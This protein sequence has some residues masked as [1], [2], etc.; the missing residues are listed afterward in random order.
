[1]MRKLTR[2]FSLPVIAASV[3]ILIALGAIS[4]PAQMRGAGQ[5]IAQPSAPQSLLSPGGGEAGHRSIPPLVRPAPGF[6]PQQAESTLFLSPVLY[7]VAAAGSLIVADVNGDGKPDIVAAGCTDAF[8]CDWSGVVSVLLGNGD[9]TFQQP[10]TFSTGQLVGA[11]AMAD[12]NHDGKLDLVLTNGYQENGYAWGNTVSV[13]LGN[14]DGTFQPPI[15]YS[16]VGQTAYSVAIGDLNGDGNPDLV[17]T[18]N[19]GAVNVMLGNGDGTFQAPVTYGTGGW[20]NVFTILADL[21]GDGILDLVVDNWYFNEDSPYYGA[22]EVIVM[23]GN[24]DGTFQSPVGYAPAGYGLPALAVADVNGDGK[25]DIITDSCGSPNGAAECEGAAYI[26]IL[27]GNG[28]GTF[29]PVV[30]SWAVDGEIDLTSVTVAD[31]NGDGKPD[32]IRTGAYADVLSILLGNG[33]GTFQPPVYFNPGAAMPFP[34]A[35]ADL[36]GDRKPDLVVGVNN[37]AVGVL[38]NNRAVDYSPT[39]ITLVSSLNPVAPLKKVTYTATVTS[40]NAG[41]ATGAVTFLEQGA[42]SGAIVPLTNGQAIYSTSYRSIGE[43][44]MQAFYSGDASNDYS[45][46]ALLPEYVMVST[47]TRVTTS[48]SPSLTGQSVTFTATVTSHYGAPPNGE[49]VTFYQGKTVLASVPLAS[50]TATYTTSSLPAGKDTIKAAYPGDT[51]LKPSSW[52]V[53]QI[54][55][56]YTTTTSLTSNLNPSQSGQEVTFTAQVTGSGPTPTAEVTFFDG[57]SKLGTATLSGGVAA[58]TTAKLAVGTH[59]I[60]AEYSGDAD[61]AKSTSSVLDQVV[62]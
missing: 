3:A 21:R 8:F 56:K 35:V 10:L 49:L 51:G 33:D 58:L 45:D 20:G 48:G 5:R 32:I 54:V 12:L 28:D 34:V 42:G 55:D 62:Q 40:Q 15:V 39:T 36:N 14:G 6:D 57:T 41:S 25:S 44:V 43:R 11:M 31:V 4:A 50:G 38:L 52:T 27:L 61:N 29:Q 26:G 18:D 13:L 1:M 47:E 17:V 23:L 37:G 2:H 46:S 9:G 30:T 60:T 7:P 24:G 22:G 16:S 59:P 19:R 53:T